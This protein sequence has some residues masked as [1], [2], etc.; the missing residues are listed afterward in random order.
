MIIPYSLQLIGALA[1]CAG[2]LASL[3]GPNSRAVT[4]LPGSTAAGAAAC[5]SKWGSP[6]KSTLCAHVC[7]VHVRVTHIGTPPAVWA[8]AQN[9]SSGQ[10]P[11]MPRTALRCGASAHHLSRHNE[12]AS[13]SC[14]SL[15]GEYLGLLNGDPIRTSDDDCSRH[16]AEESM[17]DDAARVLQLLG[18]LRRVL[19]RFG[20]EEVDDVVSIVRDGGLIA[21]HLCDRAASRSPA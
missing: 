18:G 15:T 4:D 3:G 16:A 17:V 9:S 5:K 13:S 6:I 8:T 1:L 19:D 21:V 12:P 11:L 10:R 2:S 7:V 20:E 14:G